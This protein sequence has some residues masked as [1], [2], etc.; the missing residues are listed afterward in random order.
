MAQSDTAKQFFFAALDQ[1]DARNFAEAERLFRATLEVVPDHLSSLNNLSIAQLEQDKFSDAAATARAILGLDQNNLAALTMLST[2]ELHEGRDADALV[3]CRAIVAIDP[4]NAEAHHKIGLIKTS[5]GAFAEAL[6]A[7]DK[8]LEIQPGAAETWLRRGHLAMQLGHYDDA[9]ASYDRH[10]EFAPDSILGILGRACILSE[11]AR[12]GEALDAFERVVAL[13]AGHAHAWLGRGHVLA[14]LDRL[15]EAAASYEKSVSLDGRVVDAWVALGDV[16]NR[17]RDFHAALRAFDS[18]LT[19]APE[20]GA[21]RRGRAAALSRLGRHADA[22]AEFRSALTLMPGDSDMWI[23]LGNLLTSLSRFDDALAAYGEAR[24]ID[25]RHPGAWLCRANVLGLVKRYDEALECYREALR[26]K[27]DDIDV[28]DSRANMF[29]QMKRFEDALSDYDAAYRLRPD[30]FHVEGER[31]HAQLHIAD[32]TDVVVRLAGLEAAIRAGKELSTPFVSL[33]LLPSAELHMQHA[34]LWAE[35][36]P[37]ASTEPFWNGE[38]YDHVKIR[39]AYASA[40][41][42]E[43]A[44]SQLMAG[45]FEQH[46]RSRFELLA[47]SFGPDDRSAMRKRV[48]APFDRVIDARG[49]TNSEVA[50]D[51]R[52]AEVDILVDLKGYTEDSRPGIFLHRPSPIQV[53]YLG[54]PGTLSLDAIDYILADKVVIPESARRY[55]SEKVAYLPHCYQSNDEKKII[56]VRHLSRAAVGLPEDGTVFCCFNSIYKILPDVFDCWMNILRRSPNSVLWLLRPNAVAERNLKREAVVRGI[57]PGRLV[58]A[59]RVPL[60]D[61]L[62]RH[63]LA[64]LFLDTLPYNAH[65]TS[66]DALWAGLPVLTQ[67]GETFAGRV[68]ASLLDALGL[69]ELVADDRRSYEDLAVLLASDSA[70]LNGIKAKLAAN[71]LASPL[72]DSARFTRDLEDLYGQ[73]YRRHL[74]S[75]PPDHIETGG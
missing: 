71:R 9:L 61:H 4:R 50:Q 24:K 21:V 17:R 34:S 23:S 67:Q 33:G 20:T 65:T 26:L 1:L 66:S 8:V 60:S 73:M 72:F 30:V 25:P 22:E 69:A 55:Y 68:S 54:Y 15:E 38:R 28:F 39:L 44:T 48:L 27:P 64:D 62:A 2:C 43:H 32:W 12:F 6:A 41:F 57:D 11:Q 13:N 58:F 31:L 40:D 42:H 74:D 29:L 59:A 49:R 46:D 18:A 56:G 70:R 36:L 47:V 53:S 16:M 75:L 19:L 35:R 7:F 63:S 52:S 45:L 10:L 51:I 3:A 14:S 37:R 5:E